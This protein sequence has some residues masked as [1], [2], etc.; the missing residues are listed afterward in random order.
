[1][2]ALENQR[3]WLCIILHYENNNYTSGVCELRQPC[4]VSTEQPVELGA[5]HGGG[6]GAVPYLKLAGQQQQQQEVA[7]SL[8]GGDR[9]GSLSRWW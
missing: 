7:H 4:S 9:G 1:M 8:G 6:G 3:N 5:D 2:A